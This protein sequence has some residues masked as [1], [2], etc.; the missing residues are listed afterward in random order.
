MFKRLS[1]MA[2]VFFI[3]TAFVMQAFAGMLYDSTSAL[4]DALQNYSGY[5]QGR[6]NFNGDSIRY[7]PD[8][9]LSGLT[10]D[11]GYS[12][13][14]I[15]YGQPHGDYKDGEYRY[16]GYTFYGEDYTN[17][18]F[19]PDSHAGGADF[20]SRNWVYQPWDDP[21]VNTST[22][23]LTKFN[24]VGLPGDGSPEY[25]D[26]IYW[27]ILST[28]FL[29]NN[30]YTFNPASKP[31]LW[32]NIEQYVHILAPPTKYA[33]GIGRM[34]HEMGGS[35]WYITVP[36]MPEVLVP[37]PGNLKAVSI[38]L[39]VPPGQKAEPGKEY[40]ATVVFEN[41]SDQAYPG[42]PVAVLH[43]EY[44]ATLYDENS[45]VLPKKV[46]GG[47]EVQVADFGKKGEP[48]SR[49]VFTCK[50]HPFGQTKDGLTGIVNRDEIGR[51][52]QEA[53][54]EDNV[55][56]AETD[57]RY[58]NLGVKSL[59]I[60]PNPG[61]PGETS[62][63][64]GVAFNDYAEAFSDVPVILYVDKVY[65]GSTVVSLPAATEAGPGEASFEIKFP[66]P[67][68]GEHKIEVVINPARLAQTD[69]GRKRLDEWGLQVPDTSGMNV[70]PEGY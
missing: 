66:A 50:W 64:Y 43:G 9:V 6:Y 56:S 32:Q 65:Q 55:V 33:W 48:N 2:A 3:L 47:R 61:T 13:G 41:E 39:G 11:S 34:W 25:H 57:V 20:A 7:T 52:Y 67:S 28:A 18:S 68:A 29:Q 8:A 38:D 14:V 23:N 37:K 42:T 30:G 59:H 69:A 21:G 54:Y 1:A 53:T 35:I 36:I 19:P 24:P 70:V 63:A 46:I 58:I 26:A 17:M 49:R 16:L 45:Q 44:Q 62:T 31:E 22:R 51:V 27:G 60:E 5:Y 12:Y 40:T 10:D 15:V 4:N